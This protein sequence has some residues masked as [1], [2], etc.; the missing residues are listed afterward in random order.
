[1]KKL[2]RYIIG[3]FISTFLFCLLLLSAIVVVVDISEKADDFVKSGLPFWKLIRDYYS[4]F[5]PRI[6]AM[7]FPLFVFI[8]VI[9][10]TSKMAAR[11]EIVAI[12]SSGISFKRFLLPYLLT[13]CFLSLI[14]WAGYHTILP[15]ANRKWS[16]FEK[17]Y[18]DVNY[19]YNPDN[20]PYKQNMYFRIDPTTYAVIKG[21]DT[22]SKT[23]SNFAVNKFEKDKLVYN[24]RALSFHWD[25]AVKKWQLHNV[26]ERV[27]KG[28][29]EKITISKSKYATY[30]FKPV[31]LRKDNYIKDQLST[32]ELNQFIRLEKMRGSEMLNTLEVERHNRDAIPLSVLILS[33]IGGILAS[34]KVRGGSGFHLALGVLISVAYVLMSRFTIVFATKGDFTPWLAAWLPNIIFSLLALYLYKRAPK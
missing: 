4:G 3:K 26:Y 25:T 7:L 28:K 16:E 34:R 18:I 19:A 2:D 23:G 24:L 14:L 30:S 29:N 11:A 20:N 13:G 27:L 12:L 31:D 10:F 15:D 1:M 33:L 6:D 32:E 8:S 22:I 17:K 5:L 9:F 21:Y